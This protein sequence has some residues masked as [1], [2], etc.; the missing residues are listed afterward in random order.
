MTN[1]LFAYEP[2]LIN[3]T[4][5]SGLSPWEGEISIFHRFYGSVLNSPLE[6]VF[7]M[8][9]GANVGLG[10]RLQTFDGL[11]LK[12]SYISSQKTFTAGNSF[13]W[14]LPYFFLHTQLD[15]QFF[16]FRST[17]TERIGHFYTSLAWRTDPIFNLLTPA[18]VVAY[19]GYFQ[20]LE[21]GAGLHLKIVQFLSLVI[22]FYPFELY[23]AFLFNLQVRCALGLRTLGEGNFEL[24]TLYNFRAR[25]S[26]HMQN[27]GEN[28]YD[29]MFS[30]VTDEQLEA[31]KLNTGTQ[32]MD[33]T[34]VGSNI[35]RYSR[36]QLLVEVLQRVWRMLEEEGDEQKY[37]DDFSA[38]IQGTSGQ[39]CYRLKGDLVSYFSAIG[40]LMHKLV[41][42]LKAK[43]KEHK[44]YQVLKR[45]FTE[46]FELKHDS[47][48]GGDP[49]IEVKEGKSLSASSMQSPDDLEATFRSKK[50][51]QSRGY[52][53]NLT[54]TC[55]KENELQL[56]TKV[57]VAPNVTD[58]QSLLVG[59]IGDLKDRTGVETVWTDGGYNGPAAEKVMR[60]QEVE[61]RT[62]AIRGSKP[63]SSDDRL[64]L[65]EFEWETDEEGKPVKVV[66]PGDQE[67]EVIAG[68]KEGR[69]AAEFDDE[70]CAACPFSDRCPAEALKRRP[71]R[72]LRLNTRAAQVAKMG[73]FG[74]Q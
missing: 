50:G 30:K 34:L 11:E 68:R 61:H 38:Y 1:R 54:E 36:L 64:K 8:E 59:G 45:V 29:S 16:T 43:Y 25:V 71:V 73:T 14:Y 15:L 47:G 4:T 42:E 24:R 67:V 74:Q 2:S 32:R 10:M 48:N 39:Y 33:S 18:L 28:L 41:E 3:L 70:L 20:R 23:E 46:H 35:R 69:F 12:A 51:E 9:A 44:S 53:V 49:K 57:Q 26:F 63:P 60:D 72:V 21:L 19:D 56:I 52:V 22:E 6:T 66:C 65:E 55:D 7:G 13:S 40:E 17:L 27:S 31:M 58:D 37:Q 5:P 62:T